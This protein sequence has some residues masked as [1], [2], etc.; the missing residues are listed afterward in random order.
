MVVEK[1]RSLGDDGVVVVVVVVVVD[2]CDDEAMMMMVGELMS[3]AH[4]GMTRLV[5]NEGDLSLVN[6]FQRRW[7]TT[8]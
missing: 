2:G 5:A 3:A 1:G 6:H 4:S 7:T 8:H